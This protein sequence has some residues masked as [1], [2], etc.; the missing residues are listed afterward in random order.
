MWQTFTQLLSRDMTIFRREYRTKLFDTAFILFTNVVV[1]AYFLPIFGASASLGPFI[2]VSAITTFGLFDIIGKVSVRLADIEGPQAIAYTL[3]LP[4]HPNAVFGYIGLSWSIEPF[5]ISLPLFP[6]GKILLWNHFSLA[7]IHYPKMLIMLT[8]A[9]LFYGFF[10][11][12]LVGIMKGMSNLS[13]LFIRVINP[14]FM[15]G[16]YFYPWQAAYDLSPII[17]YLSLLNP[18]VYIN[19]GMHAAVL[20]P[21]GHLPFWFSFGTIWLFT[22][23]CALDA[24]RRL[25]KR[26]DCI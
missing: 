2:L 14:L 18:L 1:F 16:A 12:W 26:L 23:A 10:S 3:N 13:H 9:C 15:F 24:I 6:V 19:E 5:L 20:G 11:L 4:I 7:A 25:R 8:A 21:Q 22:A 17:G